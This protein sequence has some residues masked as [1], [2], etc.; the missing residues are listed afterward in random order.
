MAKP[1]GVTILATLEEINLY[2]EGLGM[3]PLRSL[4]EITEGSPSAYLQ[5][6]KNRWADKLGGWQSVAFTTFGL[7]APIRV[8]ATVTEA[9]TTPTVT[10][11]EKAND[12]G[13]IVATVDAGVITRNKQGQYFLNGVPADITWATKMIQE[14]G[15]PSVSQ[16]TLDWQ[17]SQ[18]AAPT[19][20]EHG[21]GT[22]AEVVSEGGYDY[23]IYRDAEGIPRDKVLIGRTAEPPTPVKKDWAEAANAAQL[24]ESKRQFDIG[25]A[26]TEKQAAE[27]PEL[28]RATN[29][30]R[31]EKDRIQLLSG[32]PSD[33]WISAYTLKNQPNPYARRTVS[34]IEQLGE[35]LDQ[36]TL[37]VQNW[38]GALVKAINAERAGT[39][40]YVTSEQAQVEIDNATK[41]RDRLYAA[42]NNIRVEDRD[43]TPQ[44]PQPYPDAPSWLPLY[45]PGQTVGRMITSQN[46]PTPSGQQLT[47]MS[48]SRAAQLGY[49]ADWTKKMGGGRNWRDI[50]GEAELMQPKTPRGAGGFRTSPARQWV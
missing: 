20:I 33:D 2:R 15:A 46:V 6:L 48:K 12:I 31:W 8:G 27:D 44:V 24:A 29:E 17:K 25:Q 39:P 26:W 13:E 28:Q 47:Q 37:K 35:S 18:A 9:T 11:T 16:Q 43:W 41:E 40:F 14:A 23:Q 10:P 21:G 34:P 19:P 7:F 4:A 45:A 49:F 32:L 38:Q 1:K 36:Q 22:I 50:L 3:P 5:S 30:L 42:W